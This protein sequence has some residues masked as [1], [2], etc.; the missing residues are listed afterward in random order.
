MFNC[1]KF[2]MRISNAMS[3]FLVFKVFEGQG[4]GDAIELQHLQVV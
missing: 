3:E 1:F 2:L 4:D